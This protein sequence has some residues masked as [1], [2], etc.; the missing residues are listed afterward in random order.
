MG[1]VSVMHAVRISSGTHRRGI[2]LVHT[3]PRPRSD[4]AV[5]AQRLA[6]T[7]QSVKTSCTR[8][9]S[10]EADIAGLIIS[11]GCL[12]VFIVRN[13]SCGRFQ[14]AK[15]SLWHSERCKSGVSLYPVRIDQHLRHVLHIR[16]KL[17]FIYKFILRRCA[18]PWWKDITVEFGT[19]KDD[20]LFTG[21]E[22]PRGCRRP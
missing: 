19:L 3:C 16:K 1:T 22:L 10:P 12:A 18:T 21:G 17:P 2:K 8:S 5:V 4:R 14:P 7:E 20:D 13:R 9:V 15:I 6:T 11:Y